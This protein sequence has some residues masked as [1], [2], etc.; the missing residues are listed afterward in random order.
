MLR[1][2]LSNLRLIFK[3]FNCLISLHFVS[4]VRIPSS[5]FLKGSQSYELKLKL[6]LKKDL[7]STCNYALCSAPILV[8]FFPCQ[9]KYRTVVFLTISGPLTSLIRT[10]PP[11]QAMVASAC[12]LDLTM[13]FEVIINDKDNRRDWTFYF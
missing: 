12:R 2:Q 9:N 13:L 10:Q 3:C 1:L 11:P 7:C 4:L 6:K 5:P 8:S